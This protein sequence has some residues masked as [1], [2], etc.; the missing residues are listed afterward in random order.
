MQLPGAAAA[1]AT[2]HVMRSDGNRVTV[3]VNESFEVVS[4]ES[5][6]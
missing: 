3:Y 1:A 5:G 6:P 2:T 4:V